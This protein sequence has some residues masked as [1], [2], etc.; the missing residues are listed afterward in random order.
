MKFSMMIPVLASALLLCS[1]LPTTQAA[2]IEKRDVA[3]EA[4]A[5]LDNAKSQISPIKVRKY[6][7]YS[8]LL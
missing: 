1:F 8:K 4:K 3:S 5:I 2:A 6:S 7:A